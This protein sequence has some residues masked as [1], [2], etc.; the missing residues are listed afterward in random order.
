VAR[1][2]D[3]LYEVAQTLRALGDDG[4]AEIFERL[5]VAR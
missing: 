3:A 2:A 5:G 1:A 4:A